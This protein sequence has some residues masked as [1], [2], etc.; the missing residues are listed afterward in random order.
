M[1]GTTV[2]L[3]ASMPNNNSLT[4]IDHSLLDN[5]T[6]GFG[7][8]PPL[9]AGGLALSG[10]VDVGKWVGCTAQAVGNAIDGQ[11]GGGALADWGRCVQ[12]N[13]PIPQGGTPRGQGGPPQS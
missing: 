2:A 10:A 7:W 6:G 3:A 12:T 9:V 4:T 5:V 1:R 8:V 11:S 13:Q